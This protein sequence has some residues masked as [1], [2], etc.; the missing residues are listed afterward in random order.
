[1]THIIQVGPDGGFRL[2]KAIRSRFKPRDQVIVF[3]SKDTIV[4]KRLHHAKLS[5]F[6]S[7]TN[8]KPMSM[9]EINKEIQ[10]FRR[11]RKSRA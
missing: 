2:P 8:G 6:A 10:N 9:R 5:E 11:E 4:L 3:A 7:R 1:M